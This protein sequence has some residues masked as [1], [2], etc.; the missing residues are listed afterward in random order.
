MPTFEVN[1]KGRD[2]QKYIDAPTAGKAKYQYLLDVRDA[3]PDTEF[4]DL[5][6]HS[7]AVRPLTR[8]ELAQ[9]EA[10]A[11]NDRHP[12]GTVLNYW[13]GLKEGP[14]SGSAPIRYPAGVMCDHASVWMDHV[15]GS[16][17]L[18]H[19]EPADHNREI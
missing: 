3:W 19:V 9:R 6:C 5:E 2:W 14:P 1:V 11:F 17:A 7:C 12:I 13:R 16:I 8:K 18:S 10:D 4:K 15:S